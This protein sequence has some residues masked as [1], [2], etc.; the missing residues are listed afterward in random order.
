M[1]MS[2]AQ[3]LADSQRRI[4]ESL[5]LLK[6]IACATLCFIIKVSEMGLSKCSW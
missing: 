2:E 1:P 3:K 6:E 5:S 4:N